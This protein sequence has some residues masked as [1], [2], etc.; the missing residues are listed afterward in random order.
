[1]AESL[2][3]DVVEPEIMPALHRFS[4]DAW[5]F[6]QHYSGGNGTRMGM[7]SMFYGVHGPYWFQFLAERRSPV[8]VDVLQQQDYQLGVFTSARFSYP[9]FDRTIFA[10]VPDEAMRDSAWNYHA[11]DW[12]R[13][14]RN[15][16]ERV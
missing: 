10:R 9:E 16:R 13:G 2:R 11:T 14:W 12:E 1:M 7:F 15:D 3:P 5:R 6:A 4:R 8:L